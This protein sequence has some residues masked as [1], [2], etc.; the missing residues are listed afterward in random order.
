MTT[1]TLIVSADLAS[2][3][4]DELLARLESG[5]ARTA[6]DLAELALVFGELESRGYDLSGLRIGMARY[7]RSI[8]RGQ[9]TP[10]VV[11][12]FSGLP[13]L[14][15]RVMQLPLEE[16]AR[17]AEGGKVSLA[18]FASEGDR[19][20]ER[21][22][23]PL[24]L[25]GPQRLQVF[26]EGVIRTIEQQVPLL[27]QQ[28]TLSKRKA[29]PGQRVKAL[30]ETGEIQVGSRR[31]SAAELLAAL[32]SLSDPVEDDG[33]EPTTLA[34]KLSPEQHRRLRVHA[35]RH[36]TTIGQVVIDA[37]AAAGAFRNG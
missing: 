9:T 23:D 10:Q 37:L 22:I 28:V 12:R 29:R 8:A 2:L 24:L 16:Q 3:T 31:Y 25:T 30:R 21:L 19:I 32:A 35:A 26:G 34:V 5:L 33:E 17:L 11:V 15:D 6:A 20:T 27:T 1:E 7:L 14:L 13:S 36:S 4:T 18:V